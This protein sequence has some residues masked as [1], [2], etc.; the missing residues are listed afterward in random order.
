M[1]SAGCLWYFLFL[2]LASP[3]RYQPQ[4]YSFF[5]MPLVGWVESA[6]REATSSFLQA[7]FFGFLFQ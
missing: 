6:G 7:I 2:N 1:M 4:G 5:I 3:I